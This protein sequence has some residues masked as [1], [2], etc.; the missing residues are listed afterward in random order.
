[1]KA[2]FLGLGSVGQRHLR[3]FKEILGSEAEILV[4]RNTN[5]NLVIEHGQAL[6][7]TSLKDYYGYTE[8]A[9]LEKGLALNPD[10][11]FVTNPSSKHID[12]ALASATAKTNIFIEKPLSHNTEGV[13]ILE[14]MV[15]RNSLVVHVGYQTRYH[16][17]YKVVQALFTEGKF[18]NLISAGF[19]WGTYLPDHHPYEDYRVGYAANSIL[20]GGVTLGLIHEIDL[21]YSFLGVPKTIAAIGGKLS[22][23]E[24]NVD[25]TVSVL[26]G[27]KDEGSVVPVSLF[28]SY[29]Q[30]HET[31]SIRMQFVDGLLV[32]DLLSN[33]VIVYG[34][35]QEILYQKEFG[36]IDRNEMFKDELVEFIN[37]VK[38]HDTSG[39]SL[40][41]GSETLAIALRIRGEI[42][43]QTRR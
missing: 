39:N 1:M 14:E 15:K 26:M 5:H 38:R 36:V 4:Y 7:C 28:L 34:S 10:I 18:G 24:M 22:S 20:G 2:L 23:L 3:N 17:C 6:E 21:I 25:D 30:K 33:S 12:A 37:A 11:V 43:E 19:E 35:K 31:R 13:K 27:F 9:S 42:D 40:I 32:C 29:A 41:A 8:V 16:P